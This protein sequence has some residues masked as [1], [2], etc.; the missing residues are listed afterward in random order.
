MR[1]DAHHFFA[2]AHFHIAGVVVEVARAEA[3]RLRVGKRGVEHRFQRQAEARFAL[4]GL[5]FA[6]NA[7]PFLQHIDNLRAQRFHRAVKL[8]VY[9]IK[10]LHLLIFIVYHR[11]A[12]RVKRA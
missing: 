11:G 10:T 2:F 8:F 6:G 9:H 4:S 3:Q 7:D 12:K 1:Y 5:L